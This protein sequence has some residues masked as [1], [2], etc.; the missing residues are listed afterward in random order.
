MTYSKEI[1]QKMNTLAKFLT[2][3]EEDLQTYMQENNLTKTEALLQIYDP[4]LNRKV[5]MR[6]LYTN[7]ELVTTLYDTGL[8]LSRT[9]VYLQKK[10]RE[11]KRPQSTLAV[12][13]TYKER[14]EM[15]KLPT[16]V[17]DYHLYEKINNEWWEVNIESKAFPLKPIQNT[18][19]NQNKELQWT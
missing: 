19:E 1:A 8:S 17:R 13:Y 10:M 15:P 2:P 12:K 4:I 3:T 16:D 7:A 6:R 11:A 9:F 14:D 5:N 18:K